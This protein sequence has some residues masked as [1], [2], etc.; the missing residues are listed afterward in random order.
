MMLALYG[1]VSGEAVSGEAALVMD[2]FRIAF[3]S[4]VD[5]NTTKSKTITSGLFT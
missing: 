1:A 2:Y 3:W 4:N 5:K